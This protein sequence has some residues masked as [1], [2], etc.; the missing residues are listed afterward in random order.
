[1]DVCFCLVGARTHLAGAFIYFDGA[2]THFF[3][4]E[5]INRGK[6]NPYNGSTM[7]Q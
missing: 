1:M 5:R 4:L 2:K 6:G 3:Q 7:F